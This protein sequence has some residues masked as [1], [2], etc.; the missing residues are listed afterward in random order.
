LSYADQV[1]QVLY[2]LGTM[3]VDGATA[4]GLIPASAAKNINRR[5]HD[6]IAWLNEFDEAWRRKM[7][8]STDA[9]A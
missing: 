7:A 9:S 4:A 8:E 3:R 1:N 2:D 5:L 6:A